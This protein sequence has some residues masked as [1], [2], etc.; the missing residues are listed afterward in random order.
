MFELMSFLHKLKPSSLILY[1]FIDKLEN[2]IG[3]GNFGSVYEASVI[4]GNT[5]VAVKRS[6]RF[7]TG[8]DHYD[9]MSLEEEVQVLNDINKNDPNDEKYVI[10]FGILF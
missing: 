10:L 4:G 8:M 5:T 2:L 1:L 7:M 9:R 6:S 3:S